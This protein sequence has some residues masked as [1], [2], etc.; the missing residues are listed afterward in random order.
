MKRIA[1]LLSTAILLFALIT[2]CQQSK[3]NAKETDNTEEKAGEETAA[4][5]Y[6][7]SMH[8]EVITKEPGKCP[9]CGMDLVKKESKEE[10]AHEH[11]DTTE[12]N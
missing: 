12:H 9:K 2:A 6:T 8:P 7:C 4:V 1:L 5:E 11:S 3:D 10:G